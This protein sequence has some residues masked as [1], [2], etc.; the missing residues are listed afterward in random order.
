MYSRVLTASL[1]GLS[2]E[3]TWAEVDAENG[4]PNFTV[5]GL[6]NQSI[7]EARERI[8]S[9]M[10][11]SGFDFPQK[12]ITVNLTPANK[13][14][15]GS[16]YD[17][18]IAAGLL[19]CSGLNASKY[20][21]ALAEGKLACFGELTL[22]G[23][24]NAVDGALPM[25]IG[26]KKSGAEELILPEANLKEAMLIKGIKL[27]PAKTIGQ[28]ADH[29][30]GNRPME[31]VFGEGYIPGNS[32]F[33]APDLSDIKGQMAMKRAAQL[34][35][36]GMH[37]MLMTGPPGVGKTMIG[38]RIPGLLPA[39]TYEEQLEVT[40][41]YS[42][43]GELKESM[44]L[45]T[46]RPF[47]APHHSISTAALVG[48]G[49][50]PKPGEISLAHGGVLFLDELPEFSASTLD[51]L[52]QPLE[53]G[54]VSINRINSKIRYPAQFMLVAAMNPCRCGYYGDPEKRCTCTESDRLRYTGRVS[55][56]LIDRIDIHVRIERLA[57]NDLRMETVP[58]VSTAELKAGIDEAMAR[59][60]SRYKNDGIKFNSQLTAPLIE[61]YCYAEKNANDILK[62]A[63]EKWHMS[64]RSYHRLL[65][66]ARTAA[67]L[68]GSELIRQEHVLEALSYRMP[69][70][71]MN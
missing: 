66:T 53:D 70:R 30:N 31:G 36:A 55:G 57:Y 2:G 49:N 47:R 5:V 21:D 67:D 19:I 12:R 22:D 42:V 6:A 60:R 58:A 46:D 10:E 3:P 1:Y 35:A 38:K 32:G 71:F 51:A 62:N 13:K 28:V 4:L 15:D 8:R 63:Y 20:E 9:A 26:L 45:I 27:Y 50:I 29:L 52:R 65:K 64:A 59:Q 39:L 69:D 16:H 54:Y 18:P 37:G 56:P 24:I 17:L 25:V 34:A 14:K 68:S 23:R 7:R 48:G 33:A 43:A 61:K 40:Q 41:I 11:N 44:P